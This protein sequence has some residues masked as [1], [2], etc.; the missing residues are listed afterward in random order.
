MYINE[1]FTNNQDVQVSAWD[2]TKDFIE[3][4]NATGEDIDLTGFSLNDDALKEEKKY[5]FPAGSVIRAKSFLTLDVDK[6]S[7]TGPVF[8]LGKGGDK[9]FLW[10]TQGVLVDEVETP[11]F[12]DNEI[13]STGRKTDGSPE[14]VVFTEVSK[15]ASNNGRDVK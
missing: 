12:A 2:D 7:T 9:V 13:Y 1:V 14:V 8:G 5:I 11:E 6:N 3:L 15:N 4:Y 10:N